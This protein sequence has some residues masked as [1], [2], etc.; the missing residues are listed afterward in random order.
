[1]YWLDEVNELIKLEIDKEIICED[2][3][4]PPVKK[5]ACLSKTTQSS[6]TIG[7]ETLSMPWRHT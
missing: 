5:E 7:S 2:R 6:E 1:M 3:E 4:S